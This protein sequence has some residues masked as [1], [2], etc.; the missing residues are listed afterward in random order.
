MPLNV[1]CFTVADF[2]D[3]VVPTSEGRGSAFAGKLLLRG[4]AWTVLEDDRI[5]ACYGIVPICKGCGEAWAI[6]AP[7]VRERP[8]L[9]K[10]AIR[11]F[12]T[13]RASG[14]YHRIQAHVDANH[15]GAVRLVEHLGFRKEAVL[16][17]YG[18]NKET[19]F[20]YAV[21]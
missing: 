13:I 17:A 20:L 11:S 12:A 18:P 6:L 5:L 14:L 8:F 16:E 9:F 3:F 7:E 2:L 15:A 4:P 1:R 21:T 19:Y 10:F